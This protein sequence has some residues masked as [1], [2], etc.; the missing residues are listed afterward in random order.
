MQ[1]G[2]PRL[3]VRRRSVERTTTRADVFHSVRRHHDVSS[4]LAGFEMVKPE[5]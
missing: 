3:F 4:R 5:L 2:L 1:S